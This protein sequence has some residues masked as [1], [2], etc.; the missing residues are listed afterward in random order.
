[1]S[2]DVVS[3]DVI[4]NDVI[5]MLEWVSIIIEEDSREDDIIITSLNDSLLSIGNNEVIAVMVNDPVPSTL[6]ITDAV[7]SDVVSKDDKLVKGVTVGSE[8]M[9]ELTVNM[10]VND[11]VVTG[12]CSVVAVNSINDSKLLS[13]IRSITLKEGRLVTDTKPDDVPDDVELDCINIDSDDAAVTMVILG[14]NNGVV[15]C[16]TVLDDSN[17]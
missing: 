10:L 5:M 2:N 13:V 1:M 12:G 4:C 9:I 7:I 3:N 16:R 8:V 14:D 15:T 6:V 11:E 17:N